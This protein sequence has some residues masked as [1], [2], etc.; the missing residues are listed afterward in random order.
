MVG[1]PPEFNASNSFDLDG[2]ITDY[3]W[4]FGDGTTGSGEI[5]IHTYTSNG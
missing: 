4:D 2:N 3:S 5:T 1:I